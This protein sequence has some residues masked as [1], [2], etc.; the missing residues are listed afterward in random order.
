MLGRGKFGPVAALFAKP[1]VEA[2]TGWGAIVARDFQVSMGRIVRFGEGIHLLPFFRMNVPIHANGIE[3][4]DLVL[5]DL[6]FF[7]TNALL[8]DPDTERE[9]RGRCILSRDF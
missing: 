8:T 1:R 5:R 4:I 2:G 3:E 9:T 6:A 7:Q